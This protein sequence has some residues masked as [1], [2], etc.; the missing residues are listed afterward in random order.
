MQQVQRTAQILKFTEAG[1][2][3]HLAVQRIATVDSKKTNS[4]LEI[5]SKI[6]MQD[7]TLAMVN[8]NTSYCLPEY[9]LANSLAK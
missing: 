1:A 8:Y 7:Y 2:K 4:P 9:S 6:V 3:R 5:I